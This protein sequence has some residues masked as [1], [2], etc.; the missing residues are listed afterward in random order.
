MFKYYNK[1]IQFFY[2]I[3]FPLLPDHPDDNSL[4]LRLLFLC[5]CILWSRCKCRENV[6]HGWVAEK[7]TVFPKVF[8]FFKNGHL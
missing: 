5:R 8:P 1:S 2:Y 4:F 6:W 3:C 7:N